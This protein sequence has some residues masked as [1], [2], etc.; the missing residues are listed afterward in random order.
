MP[1]RALIVDL[2]SYFASVE[3]WINPHLRGKPV[4]VIP[5]LTDST[6]CIA[7]SKEAKKFGVKTGVGVGEAKQMCPGILLVESSP[8]EYI[9]IHH[10]VIALVENVMHVDEVLS[11]DEVRC[12]LRGKWREKETAL[13]LA[14]E[15]RAAMFRHYEGHITCTTG[16]GPNH[17]L[18]KLASDMGKPDGIL[19]LE[20]KDLPHRLHKLKLRDF[21]GVG[22]N[23]E[24]RLNAHGI[25]TVEQLCAASKQLL[26]SIWGGIEGD[27]MWCCLRGDEVDRPPTKKRVIGHSHVLPPELRNE[28]GVHS[29][30]HRLLQKAAMRLRK[31]GYCAAGLQMFIKYQDHR[32]WSDEIVFT[33]T[34]DTLAFLSAFEQLWQGR[35]RYSQVVP[36]ATG[37]TLF[38]IRPVAQVTPSFLTP[39]VAHGRLCA[40]VDKINLSLGK[41]KVFFGG[42]LGALDYTPMRIAF[43]RIPD[44]ETEG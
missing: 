6:C 31:M 10:E 7:A 38:N 21:C 1:L 26:H 25:F 40:A 3:Q 15:I 2:D 11:I 20:E 28:H 14:K 30:N 4:A 36:Q 37:V 32:G 44:V 22:R 24:Q 23:M 19:V 43:T 42:A 13:A 39:E 27:R 8:D 35:P 34:Q 9:R 18:A 17:F 33:D 41:N 5:M 12:D 29:V 16:L